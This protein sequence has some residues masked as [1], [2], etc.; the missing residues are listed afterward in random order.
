MELIKRLTTTLDISTAQAQGGAG[1]LLHLAASQLEPDEFAQVASCVGDMD[2]LLQA[3]P[4]SQGGIGG[5]MGGMASTPGDASTDLNDEVS[6]INGFSQLNLDR[7]MANKFV[8][9]MLS[10]VQQRGGDEAKA[11]LEKGLRSMARRIEG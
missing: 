10:Y 1:L 8:P 9:I 3:A 11:L 7:A 2:D 6:V 5:V 4:S